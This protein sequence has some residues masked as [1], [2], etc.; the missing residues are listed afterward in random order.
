MGTIL[1]RDKY[2]YRYFL[3]SKSQET[4]ITDTENKMGKQLTLGQVL[5]KG[6]WV[7][8]TQISATAD[9]PMWSDCVLITQGYLKDITYTESK[10]EW[11]V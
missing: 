11:K 8:Y 2:L 9:N 5:V 4:Y 6:K 1:D 10:S 3:Y 7:P